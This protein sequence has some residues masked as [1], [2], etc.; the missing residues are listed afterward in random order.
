MCESQ[1]ACVHSRVS[2]SI[3]FMERSSITQEQY[4]YLRR[5]GAYF[6][7][8]V[9]LLGV[10]MAIG[11]ALVSRFPEV[12]RQ[13]EGSL[14]A[15]VKTFRG[16]PPLQLAAAIFLN[17]ALKTLL[18]IVLGTVLGAVAVLFLVANGAALGIVVYL[19]IQSRGLWASL[20]VLLPHGV[21]ELP[22]VLLGT[23]VGLMLGGHFINRLR[24]KAQTPLGTELRGALKFFLAAIVPLLLA[25]ALVEA[26][27]T[28][29]LANVDL[30]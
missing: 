18:V 12:A 2:V 30:Q 14:T 13:L 8:S 22:A 4:R 25:A 24:G 1:R 7:A 9:I 16:L 29:I 23:S 15:F 20:L 3:K 19:S 6:I 26:F 5:L 27:I 17:N 10:G 11:V 21:L 28:P